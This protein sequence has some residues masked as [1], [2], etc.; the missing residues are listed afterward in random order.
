[1]H[2]CVWCESLLL[3]LR[4]NVDTYLYQCHKLQYLMGLIN[5]KTL[6]KKRSCRLPLEEI[7]QYVN[8]LVI[9]TI[10]HSLFTYL[11]PSHSCIHFHQPTQVFFSSLK[12]GLFST[13]FQYPINKTISTTVS[14]II[15]NFMQVTSRRRRWLN[16]TYRAKNCMQKPISKFS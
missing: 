16:I 6:E 3:L 5:V 11:Y 8:Q 14:I 2:V 15:Y 10:R 1:M 12:S 4:V 9:I 7:I 13:Y